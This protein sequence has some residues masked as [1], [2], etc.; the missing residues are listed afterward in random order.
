VDDS[1]CGQVYGRGPHL[2]DFAADHDVL[3]FISGKH[4]SNGKYLYGLCRDANSRSYLITD[5]DELKGD[6]FN[7]CNSVGI[8][9]AAS[10]PVRDLIKAAGIIERM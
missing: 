4:S 8:S 5:P 3:I 9:G 1:I 6:W 7:G 2:K 10:T